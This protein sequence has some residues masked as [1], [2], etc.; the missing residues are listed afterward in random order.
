MSRL[1][2]QIGRIITSSSLALLLCFAMVGSANCATQVFVETLEFGQRLDI[3]YAV[4]SNVAVTGSVKTTGGGIAFWV[5]SPSGSS[6]VN[7]GWV[8]Q[9]DTF[10]FTTQE[11]GA[12]TFY[13]HNRLPNTGTVTVTLTVSS[14]VDWGTGLVPILVL[15]LV[16]LALGILGILFYTRAKRKGQQ[17]SGISTRPTQHLEQPVS[18]VFCK[19]CGAKIKNDAIYCEKCGNKIT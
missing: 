3:T 13:L 8:S 16:I 7:L 1:R 10:S 2:N 18:P 9:G 11:T 4:N 19:Y 15:A 14:G 6:V 17:I 12:Y 5:T